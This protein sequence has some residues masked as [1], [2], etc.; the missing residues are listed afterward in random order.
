M[1]VRAETVK[2]NTIALLNRMIALLLAAQ[3]VSKPM[4]L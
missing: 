1:I 4:F 3:T 2:P